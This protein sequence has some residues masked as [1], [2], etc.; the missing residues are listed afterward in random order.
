MIVVECA[1]GLKLN[2]K[3]HKLDTKNVMKNVAHVFRIVEINKEPFFSLWSKMKHK[4]QRTILTEIR[5]CQS[6]LI[7]SLVSLQTT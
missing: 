6:Y 2:T 1:R 3:N 5:I 4:L 7:I